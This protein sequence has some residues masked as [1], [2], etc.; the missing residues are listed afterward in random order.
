MPRTQD[1]GLTV[2]TLFESVLNCSQED[3]VGSEEQQDEKAAGS[4]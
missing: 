2:D 3:E 1:S 4:V